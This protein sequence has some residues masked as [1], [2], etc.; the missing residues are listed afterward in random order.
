MIRVA[1]IGVGSMGQNHARVLFD[2]ENCELVAVADNNELNVARMGRKYHA[3]G[4][5]DYRK[6]ILNENLDAVSIAVPTNFHRDVAK[7]CLENRKHVLLEKTISS[8]ESEAREII[9]AA[10]RND[11][12]LMIGHIERFNPAIQELKARLAR[13][14]LG[15]IYKIEVQRIG[16]FPVRVADVGVIVDLSVHDLDIIN[17]LTG[18]F[19]VTIYAETQQKL[20]PKFED[21]VTAIMRFG[22]GSLVLLD[23]NYLSPTKVRMLKIYGKKGMFKVNYL[24][25]EL[26][27]YEN[28]SFYSDDWKSVTE[29]DVRKINIHKAEPLVL[30]INHFISCIIENREP[31]ITGQHGL[32]I[33]Q[34][35]SLIQKSAIEK[36]VISL[37]NSFSSLTSDSPTNDSSTF[38]SCNRGFQ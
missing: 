35:A 20:H 5:T 36:K 13:G 34:L 37:S 14:E 18:T 7:F 9:D 28:N 23:I 27:F 32:N 3:K 21:S 30:E 6:M 24:T 19:P 12:K 4:Y 10:N 16:P 22:G 11:V 25:Q 8:N 2:A 29:G 31:L 38:S 1:V 17:Y 26:Y 15:E 33:V